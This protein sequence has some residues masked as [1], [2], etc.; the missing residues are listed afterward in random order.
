MV[1]YNYIYN[2]LNNYAVKMLYA[3]RGTDDWITETTKAA[4]ELYNL[5]C[6]EEKYMLKGIKTTGSNTWTI[7]FGDNDD[8]V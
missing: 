4:E 5:L 7:K 8:F 3:R 2:F 1:E 6:E